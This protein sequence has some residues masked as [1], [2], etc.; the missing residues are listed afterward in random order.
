MESWCSPAASHVRHGSALES[1]G[2]AGAV[3]HDLRHA[4]ASYWR[5]AGLES[6]EVAALLGHRD[7]GQLV[8]QVYAHAM[9]DR[10][11]GAGALM[12]A[13]MAQD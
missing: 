6:H 4:A 7:G 9:P 11:A 3:F 8:R 2:G 13:F 1:A 10:L 5:A 12:D